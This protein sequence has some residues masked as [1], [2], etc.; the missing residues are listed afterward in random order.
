MKF[1]ESFETYK[2]N[3]IGDA[4]AK[5]FK[6]KGP[7][8]KQILKDMVKANGDR[9]NADGWLPEDQ[10]SVWSFEGDKGLSYTIE[11]TWNT[12]KKRSYYKCSYC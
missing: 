1:F 12:K 2:L 5:P 9:T 4:S 10:K 3:E 6:V 8:P 11:I 7:T